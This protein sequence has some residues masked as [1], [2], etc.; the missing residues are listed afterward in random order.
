MNLS[1]MP[2]NTDILTGLGN[3]EVQN[4]N[5]SLQKVEGEEGF[6]RFIMIIQK[7]VGFKE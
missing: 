4:R 3:L 2:F 6:S 1:R 5:L 7:Q